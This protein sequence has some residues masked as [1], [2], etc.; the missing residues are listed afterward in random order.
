MR[1]IYIS[2]KHNLNSK[3]NNTAPEYAVNH[4][5]VEI[6]FPQCIKVSELSIRIYDENYKYI[7]SDVNIYP[8]NKIK[9]ALFDIASSERWEE[10]ILN[11]YVFIN[12][13]AKWHCELFLLDPSENFR[14]KEKLLPIKDNSFEQFFAEQL[15]IST[16]WNLLYT[17]VFNI[18]S[19]HDLIEKLLIFNN[20]LKEQYKSSIPILFIVL[21]DENN[22]LK[23][24]TSKFISGFLSKDNN[25]HTL[26]LSLKDFINSSFNCNE[27]NDSIE[28]AK[29]IIFE[30]PLLNYNIQTVNLINI[31]LSMITNISINKERA[32]IMYGTKESIN[33]IKEKCYIIK[34][35]IN[36]DNTI[37]LSSKKNTIDNYCSDI[38]EED[39]QEALFIHKLF[40]D[41]FKEVPNDNAEK[42]LDQ[43]IGLQ[44]VKEDMREAWIM[45][46][47]NKKRAE[48]SL[49]KNKECINHM[50]FLGNPGTGKTTVA[51]LVGRI[52]HKMGFLSKGHT[53]ETNR[54]KLVGEYIGMTEKKTLEAID[55]ARGGVLFI[56]E[57]YTLIQ[58]KDNDTKDFGKEVINTL[59]PVL[60][61]PNPDMIIIMAGYKDKMT[62]MLKTNPGLKDRFPLTFTFEDYT[63]DELMEIACGLLKSENFKLTNEAYNRLYVLIEKV[64]AN[65]DEYF[66]NG[67]WVHN[68]INQGIIRSMAKRVMQTQPNQINIE[69]LSRIEETDIIE[70]ECNY[71]ELKCCRKL[72][73]RVIGFRA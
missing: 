62:T 50:L 65:R 25:Y 23:E 21:E 19:I 54:A 22:G 63:K 29:K 30:V 48:M 35:L 47:F 40:E 18:P 58:S 12:G 55:E 71:L 66:G 13:R 1:N 8:E 4:L 2:A 46:L 69:T 73:P 61:E 7:G 32:L 42:E 14:E 57:A 41:K 56:D 64:V 27:I 59:L 52:Y 53:V 17:D 6:C 3:I 34:N 20:K 11:V 51:R 39:E 15:S 24:L 36:K 72:S 26:Q 16:W 33:M 37:N 10:K 60:S 44:K 67:R 28:S 38:Y 68:L 70:A 49:Q 45:S 31:L 43:M 9:K 5:D